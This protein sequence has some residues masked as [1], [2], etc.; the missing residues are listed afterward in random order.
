[1]CDCS[2][3]IPPGGLDLDDDPSLGLSSS[4]L[5]FEGPLN[6]DDPSKISNWEE[7]YK[8]KSLSLSDPSALFLTYPLSLFYILNKFCRHGS[9]DSNLSPGSSYRIHLIGAVVEVDMAPLFSLL[10]PLFP[11]VHLYIDLVGPAVPDNHDSI[12]Y[13]SGDSRLSLS[14]NRGLYQH[15]I[16]SSPDLIRSLSRP[17]VIIGLN[18]D[19]LA[20]KDWYPIVGYLSKAKMKAI[21][22]D[23]TE[24]AVSVLERNFRSVGLQFS[25]PTEVNPFR[26]PVRRHTESLGLAIP[27]Y[28]NCFVYGIN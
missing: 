7:Y 14:F 27:S 13:R 24:T 17:N 10:L 25:I 6:C 1:M 12:E 19:L 18:A 28:G 22:T 3:E 20:D 15:F 4:L 23:S 11:G 16:P 21:F 8:A 9:G 2:A 5:P 26:Q